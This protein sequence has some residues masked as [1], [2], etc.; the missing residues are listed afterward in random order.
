MNSIW[1]S[2]ILVIAIFFPRFG[3][4]QLYK[5]WRSTREREQVED[6]L[7]HLLDREGQGRHA[8]PESIAGTLNLPLIL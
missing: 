4:L 5:N 8:S 2:A 1:L 7:K 6:A 3:L